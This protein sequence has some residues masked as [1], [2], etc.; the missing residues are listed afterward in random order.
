MGDR[1]G[2]KFLHH[3]LL[4]MMRKGMYCCDEGG[5]GNATG[6]RCYRNFGI[7]HR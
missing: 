3:V 1:N 5:G 7:V 4:L 6:Y 2:G